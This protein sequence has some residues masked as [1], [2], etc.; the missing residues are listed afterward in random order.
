MGAKNG[1]HP[2]PL[3]WDLSTLP[4]NPPTGF[5]VAAK[6]HFQEEMIPFLSDSWE[7]QTIKKASMYLEGWVNKYPWYVILQ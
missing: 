6:L 4:G 3:W 1:S 5:P 7:Y 2:S